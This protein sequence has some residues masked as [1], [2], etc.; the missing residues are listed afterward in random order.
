MDPC[1]AFH[2]DGQD[3]CTDER[4]WLIHGQPSKDTEVD[5]CVDKQRYKTR[6]V[7]RVAVLTLVAVLAW[8]GCSSNGGCTPGQTQL[9]FGPGS[10][11]GAQICA[12]DGKSFGTCDCGSSG[13]AGS[14][15]SGGTSGGSSGSAGSSA[16]GGTSG[17]SSGSGG[18]VTG[19][20]LRLE[21]PKA[22]PHQPPLNQPTAAACSPDG[23]CP[24][25][26]VCGT[27]VG[28]TSDTY[29]CCPGGTGETVP[30]S[31]C[32]AG[33]C[34]PS[35]LNMCERAP[36]SLN[37][38]C[39]EYSETG[40][41]AD[42]GTSPGGAAGTFWCAAN[43]GPQYQP[44]YEC[45]PC[46]NGFCCGTY[47]NS[48]GDLTVTCD[49]STSKCE[50]FPGNLLASGPC[51]S[52]EPVDCGGPNGGV[53]GSVTGKGCCGA[54]TQCCSAGQCCPNLYAC[55]GDGQTCCPP[56]TTCSG[57]GCVAMGGTQ[58]VYS[59]CPAGFPIDCGLYCCN[60]GTCC[61]AGCCG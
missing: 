24:S 48:K 5:E 19:G 20:S 15:A 36:T 4:G 43:C 27:F 59:T 45:I 54:D 51:P 34:S 10:C 11:H 38:A 40:C 61:A 6:A 28:Q 39:S 52:A 46:G 44:P 1:V 55:C 47:A 37:A 41:S 9:C 35:S 50:T 18:R 25:G 21:A 60:F 3:V 16:S 57:N 8:D 12:S 30:T 13:S 23:Y 31:P 33:G 58:T 29:V 56:G 14:S 22:V 42:S 53:T 17:G 7:L 32:G 26:E 2:L 49:M